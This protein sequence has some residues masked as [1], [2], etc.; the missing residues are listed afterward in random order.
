VP[1]ILLAQTRQPDRDKLV[2]EADARHREDIAKNQVARSA[3][4]KKLLDV[5]TELTT[6]I[7]R[8]TDEIHELTW[9]GPLSVGVAYAV[10][11]SQATAVPVVLVR[12]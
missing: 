4:L 6:K 10:L 11:N 9:R 1:L 8:L 3:E 2:A 7:D 12:A 5:N